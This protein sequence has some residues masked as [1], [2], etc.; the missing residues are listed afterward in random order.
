MTD[1]FLP[2]GWPRPSGYANAAAGRGRVLAL[3]GQVGWN[4]KTEQF[5]ST[6]FVL[7]VRQA[8]RN[9]VDVL[10]A[11]QASPAEVVRM[12]WYITDRNAYMSTLPDIGHAY[13]EVF[14]AHYPAM[15]LVIVAGL[16]EPGAQVEIEVTAVVP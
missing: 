6:D 8:L 14:G 7:Q 12:T 11:A 1:K 16:L 13:R 2:P 3:A 15:S 10:R 4:P 5:E 9:V